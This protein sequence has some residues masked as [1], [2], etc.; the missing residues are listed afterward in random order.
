MGYRR[1]FGG[2]SRKPQAGR[3]GEIQGKG[4]KGKGAVG[5]VV[6]LSQSAHSP[7]NMAF[8]DGTPME[9][10]QGKVYQYER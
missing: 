7:N 9:D 3:P 2:S 4:G 8:E 6:G 10:E 5:V 1:R